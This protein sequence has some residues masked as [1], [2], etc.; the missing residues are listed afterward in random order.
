VLKDLLRG[1]SLGTPAPE[2]FLAGAGWELDALAEAHAVTWSRV[3]DNLN[4]GVVVV[5][6]TPSGVPVVG[7]VGVHPNWFDREVA[8]LS[9]CGSAGAARVL[10][11]TRRAVLLEHLG[12]R[13]PPVSGPDSA[14]GLRLVAE[15]VAQF[16]E[17]PDG[18]PP[19]AARLRLSRQWIAARPL[20]AALVARLDPLLDAGIEFF[21]QQGGR[22]WVHGD[23]APKNLRLLDGAVRWF[24]P[25]AT[26]GSRLFD[27]GYLV[28][29]WNT[30]GL[31]LHDALA[32]VATGTGLDRCS[33]D[34]A[35]VNLAPI[36]AGA[37]KPNLDAVELLGLSECLHGR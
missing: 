18:V 25:L 12:D 26:A 32:V 11:R 33:L 3:L 20:P 21:T 13:P 6:T 27:A 14:R 30:F 4:M 19:V 8:M 36:F 15:R 24:D 31:G 5:G 35:A 1:V 2:G 7:K 34:D 23:L 16:P 9:S 28:W 10:A 22:V 17:A 37:R 29:Q